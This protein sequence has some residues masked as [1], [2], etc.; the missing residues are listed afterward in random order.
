VR[1]GEDIKD[2]RQRAEQ[3][4]KSRTSD[5][6]TRLFFYFGDTGRVAEETSANGATKSLYLSDSA[7]RSIA[8]VKDGNWTWLLRDAEGSVA[9]RLS[10][11]GNVK[12]HSAYDPYGAPNEAGSGIAVGE[13]DP[14]TELGYQSESADAV[15][16]NILVGP[17]QYDPTTQRF[18]TAD[19]FIDAGSDLAL[20]TDPLTGNRY[21]FAAANPVALDDDGHEPCLSD[22][23]RMYSGTEKQQRQRERDRRDAAARNKGAEIAMEASTPGTTEEPPTTIEAY[24]DQSWGAAQKEQA[25]RGAALDAWPDTYSSLCHGDN[26]GGGK[27]SVSFDGEVIGTTYRI[28]NILAPALPP[29]G[30]ALGLPGGWAGVG[31]GFTVGWKAMETAPAW[32]IVPAMIRGTEVTGD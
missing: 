15:T 29:A 12:S 4:I 1:V 6:R 13:R 30:A 18:T 9:T 28:C 20:A 16:G 27:V 11:S 25:A 26:P 21:L 2:D 32:C 24:C 10:D 22:C 14:E 19:V 5:G 23:N 7:G 31:A 17:R 3:R 8:E